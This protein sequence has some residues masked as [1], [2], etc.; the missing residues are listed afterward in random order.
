M[1]SGFLLFILSFG[2]AR[3]NKLIIPSYV[4]TN[5]A[6]NLKAG[7]TLED[8]MLSVFVISYQERLVKEQKGII[9]SE[10]QKTDGFKSMEFK[11][12]ENLIY[13]KELHNSSFFSSKNS[14]ATTEK[15]EYKI[16][17][18]EIVKE[19][20]FERVKLRLKQDNA[21]FEII[22]VDYKEKTVHIKLQNKIPYDQI[23]KVF[24]SVRL[25]VVKI[26]A[27]P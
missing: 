11:T 25:N 27:L 26:E 3:E 2:N 20:E 5:M 16:T 9:L 4:E 6:D 13:I 15:I 21:P 24:G 17:L 19:E 18:S 14:T 12:D 8:A 23:E 7:K 22:K 10:M 1:L